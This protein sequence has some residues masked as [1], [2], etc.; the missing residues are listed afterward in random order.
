MAESNEISE[1]RKQLATDL[2]VPLE[3]LPASVAINAL[4]N[5]LFLHHLTTCR[6]EPFL[7]E[8][9]LK[10]EV[11]VAVTGT[12]VDHSSS[13]L[14]SSAAKAAIKWL[15]SGAQPMDE[16]DYISRIT[17]CQS[18]PNRQ[19]APDQRLYKLLKSQ[20]ICALCGCDIEKK[21]RLRSE[22]CPD[23]AFS[24]NGRWPE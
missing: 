17:V 18:C 10:E 16:S 13:Q 22:K 19:R 9:L 8:L 24:L 15:R 12:L 23:T 1:L 7:L 3:G 21:A 14:V 20:W 4:T 11:D 5:P 6:N 2:G